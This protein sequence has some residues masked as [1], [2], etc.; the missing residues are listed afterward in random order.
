M[1]SSQPPSYTPTAP[2]PFTTRDLETSSIRSAAPSYHTTAPSYHTTLAS[3]PHPTA[4]TSPFTSRTREPSLSLFH[5]PS[6]SLAST[7]SNPT[8]RH[9]H[10]VAL[11]RAAATAAKDERDLLAAGLTR[12]PLRAVKSVVGEREREEFG[13]GK[14]AEGKRVRPLEDPGLVGEE[15]AEMA[16]KERLRREGVEVLVL[17]D[18]RWDWL[19]G[20]F[21]FASRFVWW[22]GLGERKELC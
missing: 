8:A 2:L 19:L 18:R 14:E 1:L 10:A 17:E 15:A 9:Y 11:R 7:R 12:D 5:T 22:F 3:P 6:H 20:E 16:R 13:D 21:F 4:R